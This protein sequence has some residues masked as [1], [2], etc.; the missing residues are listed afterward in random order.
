MPLACFTATNP[1][2]KYLQLGLSRRRREIC[3]LPVLCETFRVRY[4]VNI[5][6]P[7]LAHNGLDH[8]LDDLAIG[9]AGNI[10]DV[11]NMC[12]DVPRGELLSDCLL[13]P[14]TDLV[15]I[16]GAGLEEQQDL[17][18]AFARAS[19]SNC[20]AVLDLGEM[21]YH[22]VDLGRTEAYTF[23]T[24]IS[25]RWRISGG[26]GGRGAHT[27]RVENA[28][29]AAKNGVAA[30]GRVSL[31]K[32]TMTPHAREPVKIGLAVLFAVFVS[33]EADG[34]AEERSC[35]DQVALV[36]SIVNI[37]ALIVPHLDVHA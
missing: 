34:H 33:P 17:L 35:D 1:V 13:N 3:K 4:R 21:I 23:I 11:K 27:S 19:L 6:H 9:R 26:N 20:D 32:V 29:A 22:G 25:T 12:G 24:D 8:H 5:G 36:S 30:S 14:A 15:E 16:R 31:H 18:V 37:S 28:V 10:I 2:P 7:G